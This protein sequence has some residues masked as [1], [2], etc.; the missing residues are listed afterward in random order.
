MGRTAPPEAEWSGRTVG[1]VVE[2][3]PETQVE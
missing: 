2:Q 1:S 3:L